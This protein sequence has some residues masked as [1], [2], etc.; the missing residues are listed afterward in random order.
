MNQILRRLFGAPR[1]T[2]SVL[3]LLALEGSGTS[4]ETAPGA[5]TVILLQPATASPAVRRSLARIR[6]ELSADRFHVVIADSSTAG[7]PA[8]V[9]ESAARAAEDGTV[10]VLFGDPE[11]GPTELCVVRRAARRTAVRRATVVDGRSGA[12]PGGARGAGAGAAAGDRAGALDRVAPKP[13]ARSRRPAPKLT[14]TRASSRPSRRW[15]LGSSRWIWASESGTT[16]RGRRLRGAPGRIGLRLSD[17]AWARVS[18]AG[19]GSRPR[20]DTPYGLA[21]LSQTMVLLEGAAVF[22]RANVSVPH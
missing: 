2:G 16:S 20:V 4:A 3:L 9:I 11:T 12:H 14:F 21:A 22:R 8:A 18:V 19:L 13:R 5:E 15:R 1:L 6:D 7:D 17:W 10:L